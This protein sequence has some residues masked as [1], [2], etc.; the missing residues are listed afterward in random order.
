MFQ[1]RFVS[2][3]GSICI[4][5]VAENSSGSRLTLTVA[6]LMAERS[7]SSLN[8]ALP[9]IPRM[10]MWCKAPMES[11][12]A[13]RGM[14]LNTVFSH[15]LS[16]LKQRPRL[17]TSRLLDH[18][19]P[20]A[21]GRC[22]LALHFL[23]H[24]QS[25]PPILFCSAAK[26]GNAG[27][28]CLK[29]SRYTAAALI[30]ASILVASGSAPIRLG[31][32]AVLFGVCP[33]QRVESICSKFS[34]RPKHERNRLMNSSSPKDGEAC[35]SVSKDSGSLNKWYTPTRPTALSCASH[36]ALPAACTAARTDVRG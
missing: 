34:R 28:P 36:A 15:R 11:M 2:S 35:I 10:T 1:C 5:L 7:A 25:H 18:P 32:A 8:I 16:T 17:Q 19:C 13:L 3:S 29:A 24:S 21:Y 27:F 6:R 14:D 20:L 22:I 4:V 26:Y 30:K 23:A 12:R 33:L 31:P 9:S